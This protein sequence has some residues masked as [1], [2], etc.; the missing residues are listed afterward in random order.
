MNSICT[1]GAFGISEVIVR[2]PLRPCAH[3]RILHVHVAWCT[4]TRLRR[5]L[6]ITSWRARRTRSVGKQNDVE[7]CRTFNGWAEGGGDLPTRSSKRRSPFVYDRRNQREQGKYNYFR[8][9]LSSRPSACIRFDL[10]TME[11]QRFFVLA[12]KRHTDA[13]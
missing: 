10:H 8:D 7:S 6:V 1:V 2:C 3:E 13:Y 9:T 4:E 11:F 5:A 12:P